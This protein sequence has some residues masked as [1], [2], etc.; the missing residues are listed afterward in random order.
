LTEASLSKKYPKA[1]ITQAICEFQF[2]SSKEW[3]WTVPG[4]YYQEIQTEFPV[5]KEERAFEVR[6]SPQQPQFVQSAGAALSKM[7]FVRRDQSAMVHV[8]PDLLGVTVFAP[9]P[10][11]DEF[12]KLI[13][14]QLAIYEKI[15]TPASFK[16]IGVRYINQ[17]E[18]PTKSSVKLTK[19]FRYYPH[20][21][22]T[23][24]QTHGDFLMRVAHGFANDRDT[25]IV[26][27][28]T[29]AVPSGQLGFILDIDYS[30][31]QFDKIQLDRGLAWVEEAHS[32]V[33]AM[34]EA[35]I[36]DETRGLFGES[37]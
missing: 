30:L 18:L 23:I 24:E 14:R 19:F 3:D 6:V 2:K 29:T 4:L 28:A 11:W 1:P 17:I 5:K 8:G 10:G 21:P 27:I 12:T 33:E 22:E 15:A 31:M 13:S 26:A 20:L 36:T 35:C 34:F 25:M 9:Y 37:N 16:R 7:L 32:N